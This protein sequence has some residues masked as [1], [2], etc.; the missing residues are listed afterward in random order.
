MKESFEIRRIIATQTHYGALH[1]VSQAWRTL[2]KV[3][4]NYLAKIVQR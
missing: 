3:I 4:L 2:F 1:R